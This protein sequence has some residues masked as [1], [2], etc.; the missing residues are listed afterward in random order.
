MISRKS[1]RRSISGL[2]L[3][4]EVRLRY[5]YFI[6]CTSVVK[7]ASGNVT[8]VHCTYDPATRG[9]DSPDGRK[10]KGTIHWVD[11]AQSVPMLKCGIVRF[12]V[13]PT[14]SFQKIAP[15]DGGL[16]HE[17]ESGQFAGSDQS[18]A[19]EFEPSLKLSGVG[20]RHALSSLNGLAISRWIRIRRRINFVFNRTVTLKD[21]WAKDRRSLRSNFANWRSLRRAGAGRSDGAGPAAMRA[22]GK[23]RIR[24]A[25]SSIA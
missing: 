9:G 7:D 15:D 25:M 2:R 6:K 16:A 24:R 14:P 11:A 4:A 8:E 18:N 17:A 23:R 20:D 5:A 12:P 22:D 21:T 13:Q 1:L 10:V 3:E 19:D